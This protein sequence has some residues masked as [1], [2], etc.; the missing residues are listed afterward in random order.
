MDR[1]TAAPIFLAV[2]AVVAIAVVAATLPDATESGAAGEG[3]FGGGGG[4]GVLPTPD[5]PEPS[6]V[7]APVDPLLL[8]LV[9]LAAVVA[10][11]YL[12]SRSRDGLRGVAGI[13]AFVGVIL[14]AFWLVSHLDLPGSGLP[15]SGG[16]VFGAPGGGSGGTPTTA[17]SLL[18]VVLGLVLL[19]A[20]ALVLRTSVLPEHGGDEPE[21]DTTAEA[22]DVG[23]AAR[24]AADR[25]ESSDDLEN[26]I[27]RAWREMTERLDV[28]TP[29][30]ATPGEF[31]AAGVAA[32]MERRHVEE[33][34]RL[35]EDVRYGGDEPTEPMERR[36]VAVLREIEV[37]YD[38]DAGDDR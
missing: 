24:R 25:I 30:S 12:L 15:G 4:G 17:P 13:L 3:S 16:P 36:A 20:L 14:L 8:A 38:P 2:L 35:F 27:Y 5:P 26:E 18:V 22:A 7:S 34:T 33:L 21:T 11:L 9:L 6:P 23:R 29:E 10:L 19:G 32:G 31:A 1:R 37:A 28:P